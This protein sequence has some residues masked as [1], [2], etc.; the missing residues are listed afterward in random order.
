MHDAWDHFARRPVDRVSNCASNGSDMTRLAKGA[1]SVSPSTAWALS[2]RADSTRS[3]RLRGY[4]PGG[5]ALSRSVPLATLMC[6]VFLKW[7]SL[8]RVYDRYERE[9]AL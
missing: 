8:H 5:S 6:R 7:L 1:P 9:D 3:V 4:L 2:G